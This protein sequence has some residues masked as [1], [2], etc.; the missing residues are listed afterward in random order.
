[1]NPQTATLI[2][3][4]VLEQGG[5][6]PGGLNFDAKVINYPL[7]E[8]DR[9]DVVVVLCERKLFGCVRV[10]LAGSQIAFQTPSYNTGAARVDGRGGPL[11]RAHRVRGSLL[12]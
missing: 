8:V 4:A 11:H 1:M 5:I 6:A 2:M 9:L 3:K 7:E 12:L 10:H